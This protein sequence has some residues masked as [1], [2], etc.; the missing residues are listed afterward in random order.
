MLSINA[1]SSNTS[2]DTAS[3][4]AASELEEAAL[5][6]DPFFNLKLNLFFSTDLIRNHLGSWSYINCTLV[7]RLRAVA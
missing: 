6:L 4:L 7:T 2:S 5:I 1:A 3:D